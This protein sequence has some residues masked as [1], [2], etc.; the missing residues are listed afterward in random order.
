MMPGSGTTGSAGAGS[1][2]AGSAVEIEFGC[3]P[4]RSVTVRT[5]P[6][7]ASPKFR[8]RYERMLQALSRHG[9]HN[10]Y[11]LYDGKCAFRLTNRP[12]HGLLEFTF[13]GVVLTDSSD[14]RAVSSDLCVQLVRETCDWLQQPIVDW[15]GLTVRHAVE[16][17]FDRYVEAG[18]LESA[19]ARLSQLQSQLDQQGGYLGM[20]L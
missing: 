7:D 3:W 11:Y 1:S 8:A 2:A 16:A 20:G 12:G 9:A 5:T 6:A 15:F 13:D 19:A 4:L 10:T 17:E 18:G 14:R